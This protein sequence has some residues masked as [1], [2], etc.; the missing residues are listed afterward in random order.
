M[1]PA[2]LHRV[3]GEV[4]FTDSDNARDD[5]DDLGDVLVERRWRSWATEPVDDVLDRHHDSVGLCIEV[6]L[7]MKRVSE[8]VSHRGSRNTAPLIRSTHPLVL[9]ELPTH[10]SSPHSFA[11]R[12]LAG[13]SYRPSCSTGPINLSSLLHHLLPSLSSPFC[14]KKSWRWSPQFHSSMAQSQ[15]MVHHVGGKELLLRISSQERVRWW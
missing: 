14:Q 4:I 2:L 1:L 13:E 11:D 3:G 7:G 12:K 8:T 15:L 6:R 9:P 5:R 10:H